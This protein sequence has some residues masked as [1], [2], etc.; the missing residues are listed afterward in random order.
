MDDTRRARIAAVI[1]E[2]LATKISR[3]LKDPRVPAIILTRVDVV[4]D[5]SQAT[6]WFSPLGA[7]NEPDSPEKSKRIAD[8]V[9]GLNSAA[10]YLRRHLAQVLTTRNVPSLVFKEDRGFENSFR[11]RELLDTISKEAPLP[12]TEDE[13]E[14]KKPEES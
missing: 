12:P 8:C 1:Q 7:T 14:T 6:V 9:H 10:G 11:V 3:E 13:A 2:E 4:P 5:A